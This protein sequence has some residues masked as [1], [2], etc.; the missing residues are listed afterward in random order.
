MNIQDN[1]D[2]LRRMSVNPQ[3]GTKEYEKWLKAQE[4]IKFLHESKDDEIPI[5]VSFKGMYMYSALVLIRHLKDNYVED[6]F[7]WNCGPTN[8]WSVGYSFRKDGRPKNVK[9]YP[10]FDG[11]DSKILEKARPLTYLRSFEG[12]IGDKGY[13]ECSQYL[14]H[15]HGLHFDESRKV[16]CRLDENGDIEEVIKIHKKAGEILVTIKKYVLELHLFLTKSALVRLFDVTRSDDWSGFHQKRRDDFRKE[17]DVN[18]IYYR[19]A[20]IFDS[21]NIPSA[22]YLRGFQIIRNEQP[23]TKMLDILDGKDR[24]K[25]KYEKFIAEDW[26]HGKI[27][28]ISCNP[29]DLDN[30]FSDT[31]K[32]FTTTPAFFNPEVLMKYKQ[33]PEKYTLK[34]RSIACRGSWYLQTYDI[35]HKTGQVHTYL[36]YLGDLPHSEQLHWK[37]Y[38]EKPKGGIS[39]R[40]FKT[41]FKAQWDTS[42]DPHS[43]LIRTLKDLEK[44]KKEL[45]SCKDENLWDQ[46]HYPVTDN[47]KEWADEIHNL[48][49][50]VVE[51]INKSYLKKIAKSLNCYD[52][53][54]GSIQL[55]RAILESQ[56]IDKEEINEIIHPL[57]KIHFL[58]TKFSGHIGGQEAVK[59]RK[60]LIKEHGNLRDQYRNL[61]ERTEQAIKGIADTISGG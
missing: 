3:P 49:K 48:D 45:W 14:A 35:N 7:D 43:E 11:A 56:G 59:I 17:D 8:S 40:A 31:G 57:T 54:L 61:L 50:L 30:Y 53:K 46:I 29:K 60:Q 15:L 13:V 58:R 20:I 22:G 24:K 52:S 47:V 28:E 21:K 9:I 10:P 33:D 25:K 18:E 39:K 12:R 5:Y 26:K 41:D 42:Y 27:E 4:F 19:G 55:L 37:T 38:N 2:A 6:L 1:L 32:P 51:G 36:K 16:Y 23:L 34:H 44:Q